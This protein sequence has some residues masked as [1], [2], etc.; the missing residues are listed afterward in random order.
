MT[1]TYSLYLWRDHMH[2]KKALVPALI[3]HQI[4]QHTSY[5]MFMKLLNKLLK[6]HE[7]CVGDFFII[8]FL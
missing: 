4:K 3:K 1:K 5:E 7:I 6:Y 8:S 2:V